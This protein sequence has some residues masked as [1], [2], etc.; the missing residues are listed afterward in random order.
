M[1]EGGQRGSYPM[2]KVMNGEG[3]WRREGKGEWV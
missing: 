2:A 3:P 1:E